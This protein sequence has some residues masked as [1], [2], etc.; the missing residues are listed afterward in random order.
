MTDLST[1]SERQR[2]LRINRTIH[3]LRQGVNADDIDAAW[4][5]VTPDT[6][7][8]LIEIAH[9]R[10]ITNDEAYADETRKA[11]LLYLGFG[12]MML[13]LR[14]TWRREMCLS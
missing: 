12:A 4:I 11:S 9:A 14:F 13:C 8:S 7:P 10:M 5:D 3:W 2:E 6:M 1:L